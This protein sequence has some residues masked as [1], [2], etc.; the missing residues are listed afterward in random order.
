METRLQK[1]EA[2]LLFDDDDL[3]AQT[4]VKKEEDIELNGKQKSKKGEDLTSPEDTVSQSE[5]S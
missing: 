5:A 3:E 2:V 1:I 4:G